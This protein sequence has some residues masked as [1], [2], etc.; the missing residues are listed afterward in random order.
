[1]RDAVKEGKATITLTWQ[2]IGGPTVTP[3]EQQGFGTTLVER[4]IQYELR[5]NVEI[6][7]AETG[8]VCRITFPIPSFD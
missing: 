5:G 4:S 2:E 3:P 8:L 1:M 6:D 7:Y